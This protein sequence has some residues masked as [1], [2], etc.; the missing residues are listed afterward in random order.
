MQSTELDRTHAREDQEK[1]TQQIRDTLALKVLQSWQVSNCPRKEKS[2]SNAQ[3]DPRARPALRQ[4]ARPWCVYYIYYVV[5]PDV[6]CITLWMNGQ[7]E[8]YG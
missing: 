2:E 1:G 5:K 4:A 8:K 7:A 3:F 6:S